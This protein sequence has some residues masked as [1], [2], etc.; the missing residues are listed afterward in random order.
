LTS[1]KKGSGTRADYPTAGLGPALGHAARDF[2]DAV[3]ARLRLSQIATPQAQLAVLPLID[4]C[5]IR[6]AE[7][8]RRLGISRQALGRTLTDMLTTALVEQV[9]D[10]SDRRATIIRLTPAGLATLQALQAAQAE[11]EA[12]LHGQLGD[13]IMRRLRKA[14]PPLAVALSRGVGQPE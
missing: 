4:D 6:P 14:L 3:F 8:A 7:L 13:K 1:K 10:P 12:A 11:V 5:G 2:D 9:A